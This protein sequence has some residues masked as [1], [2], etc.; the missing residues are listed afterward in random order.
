MGIAFLLLLLAQFEHEP[1]FGVS[2]FTR[3]T[4]SVER[5]RQ[6]SSRDSRQAQGLGWLNVSRVEILKRRITLF[7]RPLQARQRVNRSSI[8]IAAHNG[9]SDSTA[10]T[11]G[12]AKVAVVVH[13]TS[14]V[15][16]GNAVQVFANRDAKRQL[17]VQPQLMLRFADFGELEFQPDMQKPRTGLPIEPL[18]NYG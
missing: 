14:G 1:R 15:A 3:T 12:E 16:D 5:P 8:E 11:V 10:P 17:N 18:A 7:R 9:A 4:A 13:A 6:R 2:I